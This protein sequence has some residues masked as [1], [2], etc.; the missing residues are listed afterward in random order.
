MSPPQTRRIIQKIRRLAASLGIELRSLVD[1]AASGMRLI[2]RRTV[3]PD[4]PAAQ[5]QA[6]GHSQ[7]ATDSNNDE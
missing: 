7:R 4:L 3:E 6:T 1:D 5:V 2:M